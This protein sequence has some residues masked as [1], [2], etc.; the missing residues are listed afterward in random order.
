M[1]QHIHRIMDILASAAPNHPGWGSNSHPVVAPNILDINFS[2]FCTRYLLLSHATFIPDGTVPNDMRRKCCY[3]V[4]M[5]L[6]SLSILSAMIVELFAE[7]N[8]AMPK[9]F[10]QK[11]V[12][13]P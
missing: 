11:L 12:A 3:Q 13:H 2:Q 6:T 1:E 10:S 9:M 4:F 8:N 7:K 5:I